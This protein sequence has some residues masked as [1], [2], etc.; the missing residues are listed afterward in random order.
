ML[1]ITIIFSIL[2]LSRRAERYLSISFWRNKIEGSEIKKTEEPFGILP[3]YS[4]LCRQIREIDNIYGKEQNFYLF[5][6]GNETSVAQQDELCCAGG[7]PDH[8]ARHGDQNRQ[9]FFDLGQGEDCVYHG[10]TEFRGIHHDD[11]LR[12]SPFQ[13][14]T[15]KVSDVYQLYPEYY[16]LKVNDFN[17]WSMVPLEQWL[18]FLSTSEIPDDAD[19][20]GLREAREKLDFIHM[21]REEQMRYDRYWMER[22]ILRNT[23]VTAKGEGQMEGRAEGRAE[24]LEEGRKSEKVATAKK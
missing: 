1:Y 17:R 7:I 4:Y 13:M 22:A 18:Y 14:Q 20:P 19:A 24:G 23:L 12:L 2:F 5:R 21:N 3:V 10:K 16:I 8:T 9:D 6:R 15:F 11:V